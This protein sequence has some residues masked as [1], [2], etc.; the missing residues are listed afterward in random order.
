MAG[1]TC[2]EDER[3]LRRTSF[4]HDLGYTSS[5]YEREDTSMSAAEA[6]AVV[7]EDAR[8]EEQELQAADS[9][10]VRNSLTGS[11]W[12]LVSRVTGL[13][14]VVA[15]GAVLGATFL[16]NTYQGIYA[17]PSL[18]YYQLLAGSLFVSLLVP[19][20]VEHIRRGDR[21]RADAFVRGFLGSLLAVA[22]VAVCIVLVASPL[23]LRL[24]SLGVTDE[25]AAD[26]RRVG[27][28]L[29]VLFTPQILL[30]VIAGT[31]AAVM[32]AFGRFGLASAAPTAENVGII[33][34]LLIAAAVFGTSVELST[35]TTSEILLLGIGTTAAV[36]LHA[37]LQWFGARRSQI[38]MYV[39]A[40]WRDPEIRALLGRIKAVLTYTGLEALLLLATIVVA[41]RIE[42]GLVAFQL[43]LNFFYLPAAIITWPV[44]RALVP[45]LAAFHQ[46]KRMGAFRDEFSQS[47]GLVS[48]A[49]IPIAVAYAVSASVIASIIA[50]GRLDTSDGRSYVAVSILA[51]SPAVI[52]HAWFTLGSYALY[53]KQNVAVPLRGMIVRVVTTLLLMVP[54]VLTHGARSLAFIGLAMAGGTLIGAVYVSRRATKGLPKTRLLGGSLARTDGSRIRGH[55]RARCC[56]MDR[57]ERVAR[58]EARRRH[59]PCRRRSRGSGCFPCRS[60]LAQSSGAPDDPRWRGVSRSRR[61]RKVLDPAVSLFMNR[62]ELS[63]AGY[64]AARRGLPRALDGA[65]DTAVYA[66]GAAAAVVLAALIAFAGPKL[67]LLA[68]VVLTLLAIMALRPAVAAYLLIAI[69]PLVAGIDRG[70]V[71]P[72]LRPNEAL[73]LLAIV[74]LCGRAILRLNVSSRPKLRFSASMSRSCSSHNQLDHP[75]GMAGAARSE[76]R[77]R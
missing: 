48:F 45:R 61:V 25:V 39:S 54:A 16:G 12:T 36:F 4:E 46:T 69:T 35:V 77:E 57:V 22:A 70:T 37:A 49:S 18:I 55:A 1:A 62:H 66:A 13:A 73:M 26:Q 11:A 6:A 33:L 68:L 23:I 59:T 28:L 2:S 74:A 30:Y 21:A 34:T 60:G 10:L 56:R 51:L 75:V 50:F 41:N 43:A 32:N 17:L 76:V 29:L 8:D 15:I 19:S 14:R 7:A 64:P 63:F 20:L 42:G 27:L 5:F 72:V 24:F 71:M 38:T 3:V 40:G 31:G 58:V 47:V 9:G 67:A 53:S 44:T 65:N 52:T